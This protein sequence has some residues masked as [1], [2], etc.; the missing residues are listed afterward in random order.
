MAREFEVGDR[1]KLISDSGSIRCEVG[2]VGT[3]TGPR[4]ICIMVDW[5]RSGQEFGPY[6]CN[7]RHV[8]IA[9]LEDHLKDKDVL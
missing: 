2:D 3:V 5:D 4:G 1:V 9:Y 7:L 8:S 6:T